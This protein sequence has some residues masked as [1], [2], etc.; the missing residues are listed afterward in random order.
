VIFVLATYDDTSSG[1]LHMDIDGMFAAHHSRVTSEKIRAVYAKLRAE[2]KCTYRAPIGYLD[3]G[4]ARK[5]L[6]PQRA[7]IVRRIFE[8]YAT[9]RWSFSELTTW[10]NKQGLTTKPLRRSRTREEI[11]SGHD[12]LL[13]Q[14][15]K[16][17]NIKTIEKILHNPFYAG[18]LKYDGATIPGKHEP[19]VS[20]SLFERVQVALTGR[21]TSLRYTDNLFFTYRGLARCVCGRLFTPY[22]KKGFT[23]YRPNCRDA[24]DADRPNL[25]EPEIDAIFDQVLKQIALTPEEVA[26]LKAGAPDAFKQLREEQD[27]KSL[28]RD[29]EHQRLAQDREYLV[30]N[31]ITFLRE[32][33]YTMETFTAAEAKLER[34][35]AALE[36]ASATTAVVNAERKLARLLS[37]S[38]LALLAQQS[39]NH[40]KQRDR[41][42]L[43]ISV[44]SELVL[45][46]P[47]V[48]EVRAKS[49]FDVL[50]R[51]HVAS[52]GRVKF[53]ISELTRA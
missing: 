32:G 27:Q 2:G 39:L 53:L 34:D 42:E 12:N 40:A 51:R 37:L 4:P 1:A 36:G 24:C 10:A 35:L 48:A 50:L 3:K 17:V 26:D 43:A 44:V 8:M 49:G 25:S 7:P 9:G 29:R 38:E 45:R 41:R 52:S 31:K 13:E 23:Y 11:L 20:R 5:P 21:T 19:L 15:S 6:D 28:D 18:Y 14:V 46:G 47:S 22:A 33:V 30:K 16:P